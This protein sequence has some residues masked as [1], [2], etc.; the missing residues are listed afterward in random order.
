MRKYILFI[1]PLLVLL[2]IGP[3]GYMFLEDTCFL[4]GLYLTIITISTVGYGDI[5][6][7]TS[8]GRLFTVLLI[9]SGVGYVMYMFSQITEA[10]VEGGYNVLLRGERCTR[11]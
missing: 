7:I 8:G 5:A 4:D 3:A 2:V 9:F 6:P 10:M 1:A 11:K